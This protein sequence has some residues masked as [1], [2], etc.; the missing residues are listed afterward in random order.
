MGEW[1]RLCRILVVDDHDFMREAI[2][3]I[4]ERDPSL[5]VVGEAKDGPRAL[6]TFLREG[7]GTCGMV[8]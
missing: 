5:E 4:L 8:R 6:G 1:S 2:K 7:A 3:A